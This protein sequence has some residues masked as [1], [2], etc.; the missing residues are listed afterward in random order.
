MAQQRIV[1]GLHP[2]RAARTPYPP[3]N[4]GSYD[5]ALDPWLQQLWPALRTAF[6]LPP[7]VAP[8]V[9]DAAAL[10]QLGPPKFK[11]TPL[12]PANG[13]ASG[14]ANGSAGE[15]AQAR[16]ERLQA[17]AV[18]AAAAFRAVSMEACG[19]APSEPAAGAAGGPHGAWRPF[20]A[21]LLVNRRLTAPDHFQDTR[22]LEFDLE[23][24][25]LAYEPGDLLAIFPRTPEAD[26]QASGLWGGD[27]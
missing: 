13:A 19:L 25:E 22:H 2:N 16:E 10:L 21:P 8:P 26:V 4:P 1:P 3:Q 11:V 12:G 9:L 27:S 20:M 24:S 14:A 7:G 18:A 15:D 17:E 6:P 5:A 23:G